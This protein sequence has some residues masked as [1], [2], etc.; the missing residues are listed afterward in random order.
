MRTLILGGTGMLGRAVVAEARRRGWPA[1]GLSHAQADLRDRAR[2]LAASDSFRPELVVN[3]AAF[4][5]V[6]ECER[7]PELALEVNGGAVDNAAAAAAHARAAFL[8]VSSDYVFDG[9]AAS[10]YPES[11]APAPL[12]AYG[13]S[14]HAGEERA[15]AY[16]ASLVV[17]TSWLFGAGGPNFVRTVVRLLDEG[18]G[19]LRVVDDQ[20]GCP[21]YC[22]FAAG[23]L[24]DLARRGARGVVHYRNSEPV[25]WCGFAR[26]IAAQWRPHAAVEPISTAESGRP[27]PRPAYSVLAV[28]RVE[29]ALER[30]VEPWAAGLVEYLAELRTGRTA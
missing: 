14:K 6:D 17:R 3:C 21:T 12:S 11:A 7:Q 5:G 15:L 22:R 25:S 2:L 10:P 28:E 24:L 8:Q 23:A 26:A 18:R 4:T 9:R 1:L 16:P 19:P 30:G 29:E 20:V 13:R 27:A